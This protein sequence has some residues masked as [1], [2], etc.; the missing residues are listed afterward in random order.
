[1][2]ALDPYAAFDRDVPEQRR[3]DVMT[4]LSEA[5]HDDGAHKCVTILDRDRLNA[6][7]VRVAGIVELDGKEFSF[8]LQDGDWNG[9]ELLSW[10]DDKPF[11]Y[12]TP[13]R[14]ALQPDSALVDKALLD[15]N[16]PF[17]LAKWD[18]MLRRAE[19]AEIPGK[20]GYDRHFAPGVVSEKHWRDA[21]AKHRFEIVSQE[22]ADETRAKLARATGADA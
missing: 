3:D 12:H 21:A 7:N 5:A 14:W 9:T 8:Q 15:G 19:I 13:T 4:M 20:Y 6:I 2:S 17:L 22:T 16:G 10:E 18:A 11:E 1:M